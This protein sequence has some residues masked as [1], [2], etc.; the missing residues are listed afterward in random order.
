MVASIAATLILNSTV[1]TA[2][3]FF[4]SLIEDLPLMPQLAEQTELSMTFETSAG[5][6]SNVQANGLTNPDAV[7][8]YYKE[9]LPQLGWKLQLDG[10]Y[11]RENELLFMRIERSPNNMVK[12]VF[13]LKPLNQ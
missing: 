9:S 11:L 5:R 12:V 6:V 2:G 3:Q 13:Y 7:N 8:A 1:L 10:S 4:F